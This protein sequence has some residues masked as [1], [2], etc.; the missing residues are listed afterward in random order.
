MGTMEA[1]DKYS[2]ALEVDLGR[3]RTVPAFVALGCVSTLGVLALTPLPAAASI[4]AGTWALCLALDALRRALHAHRLAIGSDGALAVD[5]IAGTLRAGAFVAPW[6]TI[7][8]WRPAG[9]RFDRTLLV[10]PDMLGESV[11]RELRV[12]L[13]SCAPENQG[14]TLLIQ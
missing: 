1:N 6:L 3:S 4:L 9:A 12:I 11:F 5:G 13:K 14:R 7:V 10:A 8:R 2:G